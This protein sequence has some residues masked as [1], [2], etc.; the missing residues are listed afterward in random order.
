MV[1]VVNKG[2]IDVLWKGEMKSIGPNAKDAE[3]WIAFGE[4]L[5]KFRQK[6]I[7][8]EVEHAKAHRTE[9]GR[10]QMSLFEKFITAGNEKADELAK[11]A[12]VGCKS[13]HGPAG[14]RKKV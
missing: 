12:N 1:H 9:K 13:K 7:L 10:Q 11:G 8:I 3:L 14:K 5:H 4:E 2:I 6:A